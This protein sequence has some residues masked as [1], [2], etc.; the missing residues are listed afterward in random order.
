MELYNNIHNYKKNI[1]LNNQTVEGTATVNNFVST[2]T[3]TVN[4]L[5]TTGTTTIPNVIFDSTDPVLSS[6]T[7]LMISN[8]THQ[9]KQS[10][11]NINSVAL[12]NQAVSTT[13]NVQF[14]NAIVNQ[15]TYTSLNPP[16]SSSFTPAYINMYDTVTE[17]YVIATN[18]YPSFT[19]VVQ[20]VGF[21]VTNSSTFV[22][23]AAGIYRFTIDYT[24]LSGVTDLRIIL[25]VNGSGGVD[26]SSSTYGASV[27]TFNSSYLFSLAAGASCRLRFYCNTTNVVNNT[28]FGYP[29][30]KLL[31]QRVA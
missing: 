14:N 15:L 31:I 26:V 5:V 21:T 29:V 1:F 30:R 16:I 18:S 10:A 19:S 23:S 2:G 20:N 3:A 13:S 12:G 6:S 24:Q 28:F 22:A 4:N 8:G 27:T 17:T 9:I 7:L 11:I 25:E